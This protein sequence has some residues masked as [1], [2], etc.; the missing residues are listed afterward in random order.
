[1]SQ[2]AAA[3]AQA[4]CP[5]LAERTRVVLTGFDGDA[6]L[7]LSL[8]AL[9]RGRLARAE[10][11][12]LTAELRWHVGARAWPRLGIRS[13]LRRRWRATHEPAAYP[14]WLA[15]D[16]EAR[17]ALRERWRQEQVP[18]R[19]EPDEA[20][21]RMLALLESPVLRATLQDL[22]PFMTGLPV[23]HRHPLLDLR[24]VRFC[25]AIPP[26]PWC[27]DKTLFRVAMRDELPRA[28]LQR[29][30]TPLLGDPRA[31]GFASPDFMPA[32][33]RSP[34]AA[35][36]QFVDLRCYQQAFA[37][38]AAD[39]QLRTILAWPLSWALALDLWLERATR[40]PVYSEG[41]P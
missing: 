30:K 24:L 41:K 15:P 13:A 6:L 3:H 21:S 28:V 8:P 29:P 39:S 36:G 40:H 10:L 27:Y 12:Q 2:Y 25:L 16:F 20:R 26:H 22:D 18:S 35:L 34:A 19:S 5:D 33:T 23:E 14:G 11:G 4:C 9:W 17:L 1:M 32:R 38:L 31:T 37:R 7:A